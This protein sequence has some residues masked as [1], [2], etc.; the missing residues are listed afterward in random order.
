MATPEGRVK[1]RLKKRLKEAFGDALYQFWPVQTG[2]GAATL[3]CLLAYNGKFYAIETKAPGKKMTPRQEQCRDE[4]T[5]A[6]ITVFCVDDDTGIAI[7]ISVLQSD[8]YL[9][10]HRI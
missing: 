10:N 5:R 9:A 7:V 4:M 1:A 6:G 3:D 8:K 2:M